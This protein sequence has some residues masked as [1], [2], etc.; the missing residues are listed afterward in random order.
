MSLSGKHASWP[1]RC[2]AKEL[3]F[4]SRKWQSHMEVSLDSVAKS[5]HYS[6]ILG[7]ISGW[8][9]SWLHWE[10]GSERVLCVNMS[11]DTDV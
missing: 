3:V 10:V 4:A 9:D 2:L 8:R 11:M 6:E 7:C 5:K 1:N